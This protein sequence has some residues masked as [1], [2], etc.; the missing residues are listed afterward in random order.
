MNGANVTTDSSYFT[1]VQYVPDLVA[2]E[3]INIGLIAVRG[4]KIKGRF[5]RN[6]TRIRTFGGEDLSFLKEFADRVGKWTPAEPPI[7][8]FDQEIRLTEQGLREVA[9]SWS[10]SIQF[11]ELRASVLTPDQLLDELAPKFL[12]E[13]TRARAAYRDRR[14]AARLAYGRVEEA[15][16]KAVGTKSKEIVKRNPLLKGNLDSHQFDVGLVNGKISLAARGLSFEGPTTRDLQREVDAAAWAV[17]DVRE[18][19]SEVPLV[20]VA[21]PPRSSRSKAYDNAIRVFD[22]LNAKVVNET[23]VDEWAEGVAVSAKELL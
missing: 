12:R 22:G 6:W 9:G 2:D 15:V 5:I 11:T 10:N 20:I 3:R 13:S 23:E 1:V 16:R 7:P 18:I 8:A 14:M 19:D 4:E 17:D 21:I